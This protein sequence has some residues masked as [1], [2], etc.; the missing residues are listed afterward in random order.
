MSTPD[1][2]PADPPF[3]DGLDAV[4]W[5][6]LTHAY[7]SAGDVPALLRALFTGPR[8]SLAEVDHELWSCINHQGSVY[9]ATPAAVPFLARAAA[10]GVEQ[11]RALSFL[12]AIAESVDERGGLPVGAARRAVADQAAHLDATLD[13]D[14]PAVRGTALRMFVEAGALTATRL[15]HR[16]EVEGEPGLRASLLHALEWIDSSRAAR[17]AGL[18]LEQPA[19]VAD[20]VTAVALRLLIRAGVM[21]TTELT[22][23]CENCCTV[24]VAG[25]E[26]W[27]WGASPLALLVDAVAEYW[28]AEHA[29]RLRRYQTAWAGADAQR[30]NLSG[31]RGVRRLA[32]QYRSA[33]G[34]AAE[35]F[36]DLL[37]DSRLVDAVLAEMRGLGP[38]HTRQAAEH[39]A[40]IAQSAP[41]AQADRALMF[42]VEQED[43]RAPRLLATSLADRPQA[44]AAAYAL[45]FRPVRAALAFDTDLLAAI[46]AR[47]SELLDAPPRKPRDTVEST[48]R[49][50][51]PVQLIGLLRGWG[52]RAAAAVPELLRSL[53]CG[54][55][56]AADA[57]TAVGMRSPEI[58]DA[59][60]R[61]ASAGSACCRVAA[62]Q[63]L[64]SLTG[65]QEPL[66][67]A[68]EHAVGQDR[69]WPYKMLE[70]V[71]RL[72]A[73]AEQLLPAL[74]AAYLRLRDPARPLARYND[75]VA[76]VAARAR[77]GAP[78]EQAV[79]RFLTEITEV[80]AVPSFGGKQRYLEALVQTAP[81]LGAAA[82]ALI[83]PLTA[84][85]DHDSIGPEALRAIFAIDPSAAADP[86]LRAR[87]AADLLDRLTDGYADFRAIAELA[88]F[89]VENMDPGVVKRLC[90]LVDQDLRVVHYGMADAVITSDER[91]TSELHGHLVRPPLP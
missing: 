41:D 72:S 8:K 86:K 75:R 80:L 6:E 89:G 74:D 13:H 62:A 57:L 50:N 17:L 7:G 53:E 63:A 90:G 65:E 4:P 51:E 66:V 22:R 43:P 87:R 2:S 88:E 84:L 91:W 35:V 32:D 28:G 64:E 1:S 61:T 70:S 18:V 14:D 76:I 38:A 37:K 73:Y 27:M 12:A 83:A 60:C 24:G 26:R 49:H 11:E 47:V 58:L 68:I 34:P 5:A 48:R 42:L 40:R 44:L 77:L 55:C 67:A 52:P 23:L 33:V 21:R 59:L 15:Q 56:V 3:L 69:A 45:L 10:A 54:R 79:A 9:P 78:P 36:S 71:D 46:R 30:V 82:Q 29:V 39:L 19:V 81:V 16:W 25:V 85:V 20:S 31:V